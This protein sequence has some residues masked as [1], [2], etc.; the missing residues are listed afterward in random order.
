MLNLNTENIWAAKHNLLCYLYNA[1]PINNYRGNECTTQM[2]HGAKQPIHSSSSGRRCGIYRLWSVSMCQHQPSSPYY[3]TEP[4]SKSLRVLHLQVVLNDAPLLF[5]TWFSD[6]KC[7][8][9]QPES[10]TDTRDQFALTSSLLFWNS[11]FIHVMGS[12]AKYS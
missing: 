9:C 10:L 4:I 7:R 6:L 2:E 5:W 3:N 11:H 8:E 1:L 12:N